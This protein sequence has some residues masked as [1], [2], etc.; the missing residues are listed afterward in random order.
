MN[1]SMLRWL[2]LSLIAVFAVAG[3]SAQEGALSLTVTGTYLNN[4]FDEGA[5]EIVAF[6]APTATL[7]VTNGN[8]GTSDLIDASDPANL[9]LKAQVDVSELGA[10]T[11]VDVFGDIVA[12]TIAADPTQD[13][14]HVAFFTPEGTLITSVTVGALPDMLIFT[15]DGNKVLTA[16]EGEPNDEYS[17]DPEGSVSIID[18][19]G[20]VENVTD[21]NVTTVTFSDI[22]LESL[23][24]MVRVYGPGATPAQDFEPEYIA[25]SP[26]GATAYVTL[27]E[28]N[29]VAVIDIATASVSAIVPLGAKDHN[30]EGNG[31]DATKDDGAIDIANWPVMGMFLP[32][33]IVTL[34]TGDSFVLL[35]ANEGDSR[36]FDGYSEETDVMSV[37]LDADAFPNALDIQ[38]E[39]TIGG[40]EITSAQGDTD[41][42]GDVDVLY[43]FGARSF[44]IWSPEGELLWD[45]GDQIEQITAA[46]LPD[47]FNSTNDENG[48]L[49]DRSD[50]SG[51]EPEDIVI[52][53]VGDGTYAF[54]GL[55]R[56][57][58]VVVFDV[59]D[60]SAPAFVTYVNNRD[61]SGDPETG[62]A[63]DLAPEGLLFI[64]AES[65]PTGEAL[66][67][68]AN[69]VSGS[70]TVFTI[71]QGM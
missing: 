30:A 63:G 24:P 19:S 10:P 55:E 2:L 26:D 57:G 4:V 20:G 53:Q 34:P 56:I 45:S 3:V 62:T 33:A 71:S 47:E 69:E 60:P 29:A 67:V 65:S 48:S 21:A 46:A 52:G 18:I 12:A 25:I 11:H 68:V 54:I 64:P 42:D 6:H 13:P 17:V 66:L 22:T 39:A 5:A 32:D 61:F 9:V 50:N 70:V 15:P 41:G 7:F 35:T 38:S 31:L 36:D 14:G 59:T 40:L 51:P 43:S 44:S 27:Q 8:T 37:T 28:N 58:G 49:D 23:D 16:N 1:R